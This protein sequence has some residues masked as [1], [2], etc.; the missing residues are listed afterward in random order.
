LLT[1]TD[2]WAEIAF[3]V[4]LVIDPVRTEV[5][6]SRLI[7][8]HGPAHGDPITPMIILATE[9]DR[10]RNQAWTEELVRMAT[11][12]GLPS[13]EDNLTVVRSWIERWSPLVS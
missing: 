10:Q 3:A 2:D 5:G 6:I 9:R 1:A 8:H 12:P 13:V 4:N 11:A 7:R